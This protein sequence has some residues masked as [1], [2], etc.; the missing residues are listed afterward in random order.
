MV[1]KKTKKKETK[2]T[3]K[4]T[5]A[6]WFHMHTTSKPIEQLAQLLKTIERVS[7]PEQQGLSSSIHLE[8][9]CI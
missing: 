6:S 9:N 5:N 7:K 8:V 4:L 1:G 3:N 2:Q